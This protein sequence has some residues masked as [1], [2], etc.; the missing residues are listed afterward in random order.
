MKQLSFLSGIALFSTALL[1]SS[2]GSNETQQQ[3]PNGPMPYDVLAL[4]PR[5]ITLFTEY[6]AT[7][8]GEQDIEIRPKIDGYIDAVNVTEGQAVHK[9]QVLFKISNPQY[10][11]TM[12]NAQAAVEVAETEVAN[13]RLNV[14]KTKP[15]TEKGI[16]SSYELETAQL[17]LRSKEAALQQAR[18]NLSN[19][20]TNVGYTTIT[21][22]FDGVV[23]TLPFKLGSYVSSA[24]TTPLTIVSNISK[25]YAYFSLNEK[26]EMSFFRNTSG[27]TLQEKINSLPAVS[28]ILA[29]NSTYE[30]PGKVETFSGQVSTQTGSFN[31]R[32]G[33]PNPHSLL[34]SGNSGKVRMYSDR[35]NAIV[36][37]QNATFELQGKRFAYLVKKDNSVTAVEITTKEVPGGQFYVVESGLKFGETIVSSGVATLAES[38]KIVPKPVNAD[39]VYT[40]KENL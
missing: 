26:E 20:K 17:A 21:S 25:V 6:P 8:Q 4:Q 35:K 10:Q 33:F 30:L 16:V 18:A 29:D 39:S 40:T 38:M 34:R 14:S 37:P 27:K 13:A 31:V 19:A 2:C 7:I 5:S 11:Q 28:L 22:P 24:T 3:G 23:G 15:L 12:L 36:I 32:A 1:F 9:G